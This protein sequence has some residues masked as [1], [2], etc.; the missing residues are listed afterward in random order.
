MEQQLAVG[1]RAAQVGG[2]HEALGAVV[3]V[4]GAVGHERVVACLRAVHRDVRA[5]EQGVDVAPVIG[6]PGEADAGVELEADPVD[7]DRPV[8]GV[9]E[10]LDGRLGRVAV[11]ARHENGKFVAAEARDE[12]LAAERCPQP[13]SHGLQH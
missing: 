7:L 2:E 4:L 3:V 11:S 1:E 6:V 12:I 13:W 8:Q 5:L 9:L 10:T